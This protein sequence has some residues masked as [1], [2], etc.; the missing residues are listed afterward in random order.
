[1]PDI[2]DSFYDQDVEVTVG[3]ETDGSDYT[4]DND[5]RQD[6]S[7]WDSDSGDSEDVTGG[8]TVDYDDDSGSGWGSD[9]ESDS[10]GSDSFGRTGGDMV[11]GDP[12]SDGDSSAY[13]DAVDDYFGDGGAGEP[14]QTVTDQEPQ[15]EPQMPEVPEVTESLDD[16]RETF[17]GMS[18]A[19]QAGI[20][21][22]AIAV[23]YVVTR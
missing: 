13:D 15:N 21:A 2:P 10:G 1:M 23:A 12:D 16:A 4:T 9:D 19:E 5:P 7:N 20:G 22:V 18:T 3:N 11:D 8:G 6:P 14:D 17:A